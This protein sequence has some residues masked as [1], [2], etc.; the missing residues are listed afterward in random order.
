M[1]QLIEMVDDSTAVGDV[2]RFIMSWVIADSLKGLCEG[3]EYG[4]KEY[5]G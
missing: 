3:G 5:Y 1:A 4:P 2:R